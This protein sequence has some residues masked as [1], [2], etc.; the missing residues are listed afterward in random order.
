MFERSSE[1]NYKDKISTGMSGKGLARQ[2]YQ[3]SSPQ[4]S[5]EKCLLLLAKVNGIQ[6]NLAIR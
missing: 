5:D 2:R 4:M 1:P 3:A 6:V